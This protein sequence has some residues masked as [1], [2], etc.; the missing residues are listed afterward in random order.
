MTEITKKFWKKKS[1]LWFDTYINIHTHTHTHT[2]THTHS[3]T[4]T[5]TH[6][7]THTYT[8]THNI[9]RNEFLDFVL[10]NKIPQSILY[11]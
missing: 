9:F 7:H 1:S 6:K 2:F 5:Y 10:P 3:H 11:V 8:H 4:H